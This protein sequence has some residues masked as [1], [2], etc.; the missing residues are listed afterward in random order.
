[1]KQVEKAERGFFE[2]LSNENKKLLLS[3]GI[4]RMYRKGKMLFSKGELATKVFLIL[5]G[6]IQLSNQ[7]QNKD[8]SF[9]QI[10]KKNDLIGALILSKRAIYINSA[11]VLGRTLLVE[12]HKETFEEL[13]ITNAEFTVNYMQWLSK[14]SNLLLNQYHDALVCSNKNSIILSL[15]RLCYTA[16]IHKGNGIYIKKRNSLDELSRC[17]GVTETEI[18]FLLKSLEEKNI[19]TNKNRF[20]IVHDIKYFKD[21]LNCNYCS[22]SNCIQ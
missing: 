15:I 19:I 13:I 21:Q 5:D 4:E 11:E 17:E 20:I 2:S 6:K 3:S 18:D 12:F 10:M 1:M 16:G 9:Y 8:H 14:C 7:I 22:N